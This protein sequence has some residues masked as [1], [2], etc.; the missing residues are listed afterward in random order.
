MEAPVS[1]SARNTCAA[2]SGVHIGSV[3]PCSGEYVQPKTGQLAVSEKMD[4]SAHTD[5]RRGEMHTPL[6][7]T[8]TFSSGMPLLHPHSVPRCNIFILFFFFFLSFSFHH[9]QVYPVERLVQGP[10]CPSCCT[11]GCRKQRKSRS[12]VLPSTTSTNV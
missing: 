12:R 6:Y 10:P 3:I 8:C 4:I 5:S 1:G 2:A 7:L 9:Y 11:A